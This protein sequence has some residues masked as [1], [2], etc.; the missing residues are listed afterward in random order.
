MRVRNLAVAT[1]VAALAATGLTLPL[2]GTASA[3]P[4]KIRADY[5][6]D[7]FADLAVGVPGATVNGKAKAGYVNVVWGGASPASASTARPPSARPPRACPA[8]WRRAT[9]SASPSPRTT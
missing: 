8:P 1:S 2:A 9:G 7:G 5:N 3:A 6:G 4:S